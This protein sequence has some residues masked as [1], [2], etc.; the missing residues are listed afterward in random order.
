MEPALFQDPVIQTA[1]VPVA[2]TLLLFAPLRHRAGI[3]AWLAVVAGWAAALYLIKGFDLSPLRSTEKIVAATLGGLLLGL[4]LEWWR[5]PRRWLIVLLAL[6]AAAAAAWLLWPRLKRLE[7]VDLWMMAV[8]PLGVAVAVAA[9]AD[10]RRH[11]GRAE[12]ALPLLAAATG[13]CAM[14]AASALYGQLALALAAAL[15]IPVALCLTARPPAHL[16]WFVL[17]PGALLCA[18][19][20]AGAVAYARLPWPAFAAL[21]S[22][23]SLAWL[24]PLSRSRRA[25]LLVALA[26]GAVPAAVALHFTWKAAGGPL[27]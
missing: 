8:L 27:Y 3:W 4:A 17:L 9:L 12:G 2:V 23:A 25:A 18:L 1:A 11:P 14:L 13:G 21:V 22:I 7:G 6:F 16:P 15:A 10:L 20:A 5:P 26:A 24:V 19:L